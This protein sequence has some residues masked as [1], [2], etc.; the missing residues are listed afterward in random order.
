MFFPFFFVSVVG[1]NKG[2]KQL[3]DVSLQVQTKI[4]PG[5][6]LIPMRSLL[7]PS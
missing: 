3:A 2:V 1:R 5:L 4:E 7:L 6:Q